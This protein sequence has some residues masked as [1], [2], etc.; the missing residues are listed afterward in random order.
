MVDAGW[1]FYW[2]DKTLT[3]V[4]VCNMA[5][6]LFGGGTI[7][8]LS[9]RDD[10]SLTDVFRQTRDEIAERFPWSFATRRATLYPSP[11]ELANSLKEKMNAHAAD[12]SMHLV[13]DTTNFPITTDDATSLDTLYP[14]IKTLLD[15]YKAHDD[16]ARLG[17]AWVF[18][19]AQETADNQLESVEQPTTQEEAVERLNDLLTKYNSHDTDGDTHDATELNQDTHEECAEPAFEY[20]YDY[21]LPEDYMNRAELYNSG[22]EFVIEGNRILTDDSILYLKYQSRAQNATTY[23]RLYTQCLIYK[24]AAKL[25]MAIGRDFGLAGSFDAKAEKLMLDNS[26]VNTYEGNREVTRPDSSWQSH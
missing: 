24:L 10:L 13:A 2:Y 21:Y 22:A 7:T 26:L 19:H 12:T 23:S 14:L 20:G 16:D 4:Q 3:D 15:A 18:H 8:A 9:D 17:A 5:L 25:L 11:I 6:G 1:N